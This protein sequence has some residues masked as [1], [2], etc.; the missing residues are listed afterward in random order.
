MQ[1]QYSAKPSS[2]VGTA[3]SGTLPPSALAIT[4]PTNSATTGVAY[5]SFYFGEGGVQAYTYATSVGSL[6][7]NLTLD[8]A[9]GALTG[10]PDTVGDISFTA[11]VTDSA[12]TPSWVCPQVSC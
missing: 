5:S 12:A 8:T 7:H 2:Y 9:T 3:Y 11:Q 1:V 4:C 10:T 6:P